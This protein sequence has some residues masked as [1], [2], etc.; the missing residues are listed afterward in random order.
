ML[1]LPYWAPA[2]LD[3]LLIHRHISVWRLSCWWFHLGCSSL[4]SSQG[5][6]WY[7]TSH[8]AFSH[9]LLQ[10]ATYQGSPPLTLLF[11]SDSSLPYTTLSSVIASVS[12][13]DESSGGRVWSSLIWLLLFIRYSQCL[14]N[15]A[16][17]RHWMDKIS[18]HLVL[19]TSSSI[20]NLDVR[21]SKWLFDLMFWNST[22]FILFTILPVMHRPQKSN[23]NR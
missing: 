8:R 16:D 17:S 3:P 20:V 22:T 6:S 2:V 4:G 1:S 9:H 15:L 12:H 21:V 13:Y 18:P 14:N 10:E 5:L 23:K 19:I 7:I 11:F